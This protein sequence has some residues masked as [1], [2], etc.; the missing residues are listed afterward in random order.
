MLQDA[1]A[2]LKPIR[3]GIQF[4]HLIPHEDCSESMGTGQASRPAE[5]IHM[6]VGPD[7]GPRRQ[8]FLIDQ[9]CT[10]T[11][12]PFSILVLVVLQL[13]TWS[14]CL[15]PEVTMLPKFKTTNN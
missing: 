11:C 14:Q 7:G 2:H 9:T 4:H 1:Y 3:H 12:I 5:V 15:L 6:G 8:D 10:N 13:Q